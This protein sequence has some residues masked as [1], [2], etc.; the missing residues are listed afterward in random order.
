MV[1][2]NVLIDDD[3][4]YFD[5]LIEDAKIV[6]IGK[7]IDDEVVVDGG[8]N[9]LLPGIIDLN[10]RVKNATLTSKNIELLS[11]EALKGGVT[12]VLL[13]PDFTPR[14]DNETMLDFLNHKLGTMAINFYESASL[15]IKEG[16][17]LNNVGTLVANG[18]SAI[19]S[20]SS[21]NANLIRRGLQYA[22]MKS[23]PLCCNCYEPSLDDGGVMN[24]GEISFKLGLSGISKI[25]E[26]AEVAKMCEVAQNYNSSIVCQSISTYRSLELIKNAKDRGVEVY[27]E[28]SIHHLCKNDECCDGFNTLAKIKPP[29]RE[30]QER[31][32][33]LQALRD[34]DIDTLTSAHSPYSITHKDV[35]F[36]EASF[37]I[38][39]I[40]DLLPLTYTY[41]VKT[42]RKS[43]V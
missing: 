42:D 15:T 43:V 3:K 9:W 39:A 4:N 26:I 12:T 11:N 33:L 18:A 19:W 25:A 16:T 2:K 22:N 31:L 13:M 30:E 10:I 28:V 32:K 1:I 24:E 34:G 14:V 27:S 35:S 17:T 7:D 8:G 36:D 38:H 20:N 5:V 6:K 41:L 29:L 37:G 40:S 21:I 23:V